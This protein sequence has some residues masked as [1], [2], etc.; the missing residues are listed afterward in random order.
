MSRINRFLSFLQAC[1][2]SR[3]CVKEVSSFF[4]DE[5]FEILE[6]D[7]IWDLQKEGKYSIARGGSIAAFHLPKTI[8]S[9]IV[10]FAA[11]TDSPGLKIKPRPMVTDN[12]MGLL[13]VEVYGSPILHS[14][15]NRDLA[16]AGS[17]FFKTPEGGIREQLLFLK[18][19]PLIIPELA[20][21]LQRE[22]NEK[23]PLLNKQ[24]HLMPVFSL[25][26][27]TSLPTFETLLRK[28]CDCASLLSFDLFLVPVEPPGLLGPGQEW[29][30]SY[31]LDNLTGVHAAM[32]AMT[33]YVPSSVLPLCV[34]WD[35][36]EIG[37]RSWEGAGSSFLNDLLT[38]IRNFYG[39]SEEEFLVL[40]RNSFCLSLDMAHGLNPMHKQKYDPN[41]Q[42]ILGRGIVLKQ[43]ADRKYA[44]SGETLARAILL[45]K[46]SKI[47]LQ[48][49]VSRS[50]QPCGSTVGPIL[51][52]SSGIPTVDIGC[53]QLS[54]HSAREIIARDDYFDCIAFLTKAINP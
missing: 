20:I 2:T 40:K 48:H 19:T 14:W 33:S 18:D 11:H 52:A 49:Y 32:T 24:E 22:V 1:P 51:A 41:H 47:P 8:P 46:K 26:A 34:F 43:N 4:A 23:G 50:D 10:L 12:E 13:E 21:H 25:G 45:G 39:M 27:E 3:H 53:P 29:I 44:S 7:R 16:I 6:E 35:H 38:R 54:M 30:A 5:H 17:A 37:S 36:E 15:L 31:R 42:P 9:Q 28:H